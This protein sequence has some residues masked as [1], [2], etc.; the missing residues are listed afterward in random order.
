MLCNFEVIWV[1]IIL[2][3]LSQKAFVLL[4]DRQRFN[5]HDVNVLKF[6]KF[7]LL[8]FVYEP[9]FF[10]RLELHTNGLKFGD[11]RDFQIKVDFEFVEMFQ[12]LGN[13]GELNVAIVA[14]SV[15]ICGV[16][17]YFIVAFVRHDRVDFGNQFLSIVL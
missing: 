6:E 1:F 17:A 7:L 4:D 2:F 13:F 12:F 3:Y 11:C 15:D 16:V 8:F 9:N 14:F 5:F 10:E